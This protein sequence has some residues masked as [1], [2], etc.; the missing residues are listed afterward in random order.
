MS[1]MA[2]RSLRKFVWGGSAEFIP[3]DLISGDSVDAFVRQQKATS[4]TS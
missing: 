3:I 1:R 2:K 4:P